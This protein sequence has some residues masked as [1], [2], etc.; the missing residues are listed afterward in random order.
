[1]PV[2]VNIGPAPPGPTDQQ[3]I[4]GV[5]S[6]LDTVCD[7]TG[8]TK[9]ADWLR[10]KIMP[11]PAPPPPAAQAKEQDKAQPTTQPLTGPD[12]AKADRERKKSDKRDRYKRKEDRQDK[13]KRKQGPNDPHDNEGP[14]HRRPD[15][16]TIR[17]G[18]KFEE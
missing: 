4:E 13:A 7:Y 18:R 2:P 9:L 17:P 14:H 10:P 12:K 3:I 5:K 6:V 16:K 15:P 8:I 11:G 1:M